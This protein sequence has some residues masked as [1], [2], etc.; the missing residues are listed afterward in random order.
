MTPRRYYSDRQQYSGDLRQKFALNLDSSGRADPVGTALGSGGCTPVVST[1]NEEIMS[2]EKTSDFQKAASISESGT[3]NAST[4][5]GSDET[6]TLLLKNIVSGKEPYHSDDANAIDSVRLG[7]SITTEVADITATD[8]HCSDFAN[9]ATVLPIALL[10]NKPDTVYHRI[11]AASAV[12]SDKLSNRVIVASAVESDKDSVT[13]EEDR[14]K[15]NLNKFNDTLTQ[16][17]NIE[18][19]SL[20]GHV[21]SNLTPQYQHEGI[22]QPTVMRNATNAVIDNQLLHDEDIDAPSESA[23][24]FEEVLIPDVPKVEKRVELE[25]KYELER[26][27]KKNQEGLPAS[28]LG[29]RRTSLSFG[30]S[31]LSMDNALGYRVR[32]LEDLFSSFDAEVQLMKAINEKE[33]NTESTSDIE[34]ACTKE[35]VSQLSLRLNSIEELLNNFISMNSSAIF[36][37]SSTESHGVEGKKSD[38]SNTP[39]INSIIR[40]NQE[41]T[42]EY[43][44]ETK[45]LLSEEVEVGDL[46]RSP[47]STTNGRIS[48]S[49]IIQDFPI[50]TSNEQQTDDILRLVD[51]QKMLASQEEA[52]KCEIHSLSTQIDSLKEQLQEQTRRPS[53]QD[54]LSSSETAGPEKLAS[55]ALLDD[56]CGRIDSFAASLA[57]VERKTNSKVALAELCDLIQLLTGEG[58][59]DNDDA[60]VSFDIA[61]QSLSLFKKN[62]GSAMKLLHDKKADK[63]DLEL[64]IRMVEDKL[65]NSLEELIKKNFASTEKVQLKLQRDVDDCRSL[66]DLF[67]SKLQFLASAANLDKSN[68]SFYSQVDAKIQESMHAVHASLEEAV[69]KKLEDI[70]ALENELERVTSQLA[71]KPDEKQ[72]RAMFHDLE[73]TLSARIGSG[74]TVQIL[75]DSIRMGTLF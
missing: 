19:P 13:A 17:Q 44:G 6:A 30:S 73:Q 64:S 71:E 46:A 56:V 36:A 23:E 49:T 24:K 38:A 54:I 45:E 40:I 52:F 65:Q 33:M 58:P 25:V 39:T 72:L 1:R 29:A 20:I 41:E 70:G 26:A 31:K 12:D 32:R 53:I 51:V 50:L 2:N 62:F 43:R 66:L 14:H 3:S 57:V 22:I 55:V 60:Q 63:K 35:E 4:K 18:N 9:S 5:S 68:S 69:T 16:A 10:R 8:D 21:D 61:V 27:D 48:D 11:I 75:L 74:T 15:S 67:D 42:I 34:E 59:R 37:T 47:A 28:N 7:P